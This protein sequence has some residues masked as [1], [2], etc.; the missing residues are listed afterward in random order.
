ME[1]FDNPG[2]M[3]GTVS[4]VWEQ[5]LVD[6]AQAV[7]TEALH[8]CLRMFLNVSKRFQTFS[9]VRKLCSADVNA[10]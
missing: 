9:N 8:A 2:A 6:V 10:P 4:N 5:L 3:V 1:S 7:W